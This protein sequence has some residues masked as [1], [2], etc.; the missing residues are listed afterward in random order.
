MA[1]GWK[2][3]GEISSSALVR[4]SVLGRCTSFLT[5]VTNCVDYPALYLLLTSRMRIVDDDVSWKS[6]SNVQE[7]EEEVEEGDLPVV[8]VWLWELR[9]WAGTLRAGEGGSL[10][11]RF[12]E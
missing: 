6:I 4:V 8:S 10:G 1:A 9:M 3:G 12:I 11:V 5:T 7:E 2:G